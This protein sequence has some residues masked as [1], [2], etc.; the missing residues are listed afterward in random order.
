MRPSGNRFD[1][2]IS[3]PRNAYNYSSWTAD[4]PTNWTE[5]LVSAVNGPIF[6]ATS[7]IVTVRG[8][9]RYTAGTRISAIPRGSVRGTSATAG[10]AIYLLRPG[11][12]TRRLVMT[13]ELASAGTVAK[14]YILMLTDKDTYSATRY[15]T[16]IHGTPPAMRIESRAGTV[17]AYLS[18]DGGLTWES[19][20]SAIDATAFGTAGAG[21]HVGIGAYT[22]ESGTIVN[23][24][25]PYA[26]VEA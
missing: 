7:A 11:T 14:I 13:T 4:T 19:V 1:A 23:T 16:T 25:A 17:T 9:G 3:I 21:T 18:S 24:Y 8:G 2:L 5:A 20:Y 6:R 10:Q 22:G 15:S 26:L 12:D